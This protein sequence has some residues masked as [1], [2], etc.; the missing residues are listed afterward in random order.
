LDSQKP[1]PVLG[2]SEINRKKKKINLSNR[3]AL[4]SYSISMSDFCIIKRLPVAHLPF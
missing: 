4:S 2:S 1:F 3:V